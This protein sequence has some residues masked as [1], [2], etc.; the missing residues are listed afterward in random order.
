M[1]KKIQEKEEKWRKE[2][3]KEIK[4]WYVRNLY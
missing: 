2:Q 3:E 4:H 1:K